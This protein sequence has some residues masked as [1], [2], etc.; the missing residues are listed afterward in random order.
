MLKKEDSA[1]V[2]VLE[3]LSKNYPMSSFLA[4]HS[5]EAERP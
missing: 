2:T 1:K 5:T 4:N 3:S